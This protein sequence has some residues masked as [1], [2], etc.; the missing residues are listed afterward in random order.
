M[1]LVPRMAF[2]HRRAKVIAHRHDGL[3]FAAIV[4]RGLV[5]TKLVNDRSGSGSAL[6]SRLFPSSPTAVARSADRRHGGPGRLHSVWSRGTS[7][8]GRP[9]GRRAAGGAFD[10]PRQALHGAWHDGLDARNR[11]GREFPWSDK[12]KRGR[13][14]KAKRG[15]R[16]NGVGRRRRNGLRG[17]A[18]SRAVPD[19][20]P[21]AE[22]TGT[23]VA[24][25][26]RFRF[27][28]S[29]MIPTGDSGR[30][31]HRRVGPVRGSGI[32]RSA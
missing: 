3:H 14:P 26:N 28:T 21:R 9:P 5:Q 32:R 6:F 13:A 7:A 4:S 18:D 30:A 11:L 27:I 19:S 29:W 16:Q 2:F 17:E 10:M 1:Q 22:T 25:R 12:A 31:T 23:D 20:R 24:S 8:A 15:R